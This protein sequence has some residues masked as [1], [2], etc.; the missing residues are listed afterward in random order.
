MTTDNFYVIRGGM[1]SGKSTL[2]QRF[3][4]LGFQVMEEPARRV[5]ADQ[6]GI[7]NGIPCREALLFVDLILSKAIDDYT[8]AGNHSGPVIFDRGIPDNL[9]YAALSGFDYLP[10]QKAAQEYRYN[11]R[12]FFVPAWEQIYTNA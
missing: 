1:G 3:R 7:S 5:L 11:S 6:R 8:V 9:G 2:L 10:A 4:T 12:V